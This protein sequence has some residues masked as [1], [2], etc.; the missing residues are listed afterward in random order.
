MRST[1]LTHPLSIALGPQ[2]KEVVSLPTAPNFVHFMADL[3]DVG[4]FNI[5]ERSSLCKICHFE[6]RTKNKMKKSLVNAG[7]HEL[8]KPLLY[9][10]PTTLELNIANIL[11]LLINYLTTTGYPLPNRAKHPTKRDG[12][13]SKPIHKLHKHPSIKGI[14]TS[15]LSKRKRRENQHYPNPQTS[16]IR[17]SQILGATN[18]SK[19]QCKLGVGRVRSREMNE[20]PE[21][22]KRFQL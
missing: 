16:L 17:V 3:K 7:N 11:I 6:K 2:R 22:P 9:L 4:K 19:T 20:Q 15:K 8:G 18:S 14:K 10:V 12:K 1:S 21:L 5:S 13:T